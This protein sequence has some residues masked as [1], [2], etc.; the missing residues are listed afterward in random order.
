MVR[1]EQV[2]SNDFLVCTKIYEFGKSGED[3]WFSKL[4]KSMNGSPSQSTISKSI[5]RLFDR[6]MIDGEWKKVEGRWT[7]TFKITGEFEG[8]VQGLYE[9]TE[10]CE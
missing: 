3:V 10:E 8:F 1:K 2:L 4:V 9:V 7:R 6:G 5:D